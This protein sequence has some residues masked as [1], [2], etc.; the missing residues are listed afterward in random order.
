MSREAGYAGTAQGQSPA[1]ARRRP[2]ERMTA[3]LR[4]RPKCHG[5][6][7]AALD[8][9]GRGALLCRPSNVLS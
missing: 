8:P 4:H 5:H 9:A 1:M 3:A 2:C 7:R 6:A